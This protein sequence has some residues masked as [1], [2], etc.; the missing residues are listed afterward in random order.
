MPRFTNVRKYFL[1]VFYKMWQ[2]SLSL[3]KWAIVWDLI[4][5]EQHMKYKKVMKTRLEK[6]EQRKTTTFEFYILFLFLCEGYLFFDFFKSNGI[7][8]VLIFF[9][10]LLVLSNSFVI[11]FSAF[12]LFLFGAESC[13]KVFSLFRN[14]VFIFI[15]FLFNVSFLCFKAST[16][17]RPNE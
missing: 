16:S 5:I 6:N 7:S 9:N 8:Y 3:V 4:W 12:C 2:S 11:A 13:P 10:M 17:F 15:N 14:A 1:T